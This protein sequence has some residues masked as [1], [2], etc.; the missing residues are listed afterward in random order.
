M[1][2]Q[3]DFDQ[4]KG[5]VSCWLRHKKPLARLSKDNPAGIFGRVRF[6]SVEQRAPRVKLMAF[7]LKSILRNELLF[8]GVE[9]IPLDE[10]GEGYSTNMAWGGGFVCFTSPLLG[11]KEPQVMQEISGVLL[12][13]LYAQIAFPMQN[14]LRDLRS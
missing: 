5:D 14:A 1:E 8:G 10:S 3:R 2:I 9:V 11:S 13:R 7:E 4:V 6:E 12:D